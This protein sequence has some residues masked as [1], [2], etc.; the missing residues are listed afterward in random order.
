MKTLRKLIDIEG[1]YIK[2][3]KRLAKKDN[4]DLKNFIQ[5]ELYKLVK[6]EN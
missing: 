4:K 6:N 3:L 1:A 5:D 2:P